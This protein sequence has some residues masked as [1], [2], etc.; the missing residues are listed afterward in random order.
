MNVEHKKA[1]MCV[2]CKTENSFRVQRTI[3]QP[4]FVRRYKKCLWCGHNKV[5]VE[6]SSRPANAEPAAEEDK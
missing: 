3:S 1:E 2:K 5:V 6:R 4:G